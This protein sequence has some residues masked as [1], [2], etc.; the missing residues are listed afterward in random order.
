M[1]GLP[2]SVFY[3]TLSIGG[4]RPAGVLHGPVYANLRVSKGASNIDLWEDISS[5]FR[6]HM[7]SRPSCCKPSAQSYDRSLKLYC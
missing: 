2:R 6:R 5:T 7:G 3:E 1:L 4:P